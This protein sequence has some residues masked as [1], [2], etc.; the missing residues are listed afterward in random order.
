MHTTPNDE[1]DR[2]LT[3]Q[4]IEDGYRVPVGTLEHVARRLVAARQQGIKH[5][6]VK[7]APYWPQRQTERDLTQPEAERIVELAA[8]LITEQ[9]Q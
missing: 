7:V 9:E 6:I 2:G 4:V 3:Y 5:V 1:I 8:A